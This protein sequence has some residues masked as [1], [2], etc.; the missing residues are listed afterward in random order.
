MLDDAEVVSA[1]TAIQRGTRSASS[2]ESYRLDFKTEKPAERE[3]Y[4]D[5]A[6]AAVCFANASGGLIVVGVADKAVGGDALVGTALDSDEVRARIHA[7][8][9]PSIVT[10]CKEIDR[11]GVRLLLIDVPEGLDVHATRR[12]VASRRWNDECLPMR[13]ADVSRL[14]DERR[15]ADWT[16]R[17]SGRSPGDLDPDAMLRVRSLLR[18]A[19]DDTRRALGIA[20]D[21]DVLEGLRLVHSDGTLTRAADLLLC[22]SVDPATDTVLVYQYRNTPGGEAVVAR[23]WGTPMV[24]AFAEA[25]DVIGARVGTTPVNT[26]SGQ[27][28][29]IEDYPLAAVREALA[30][31]LLHGDHRE[32]RPVQVE[33]SPDSLMVRSPGPLVAGIT[34][35]NILTAGS[36]ARFPLLAGVFRTLGLAEELGQGVDRMFREMVRT[37][38][39]TPTVAVEYGTHDPATVVSLDGGPPNVRLTRFVADLP[40]AE[41]NDT[42]TLLV[43]L[44]LCRRKSVTAK[45]VAPVVQRGTAAT[46]TILRRLA[47][48][49]AQLLEPTAGTGGRRHPNYRLRS[50]AL[51]ALGPAASYH[52]PAAGDVDRKVVDHVREYETVNS[53]TVQRLFDVDVYR[54]RD[55]LRD[56]VG[57]EI[58]V[59][60]SR[61]TRGPKVK[62]GPGPAF[63]AKRRRRTT[64]EQLP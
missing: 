46:E 9:E 18:S 59:R 61:Q 14:D 37:G 41:R 50:A 49:E 53:G 17:S 25:M 12:G 58:L 19:S 36:R 13:P 31:A 22:R 57:R 10:A 54:A 2:L 40:E 34:P 60:T 6:D 5:L 24:S 64:P 30:N 11:S 38:R 20:P 21:L 23:H 32:R 63:P 47:S 3:T 26:S 7:L 16:S 55:M 43:V 8:T 45:D 27:Q 56:L 4:Q 48:G 35:E 28:L 1:L 33:H 42:D 52:R 39:S 51:V 44:L 15:G 29:Q 62:Y